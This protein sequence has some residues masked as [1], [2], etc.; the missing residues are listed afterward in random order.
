M[1]NKKYFADKGENNM[2]SRLFDELE[3]CCSLCEH[4][5]KIEVSG[6]YV[7]TRGSRLLRVE[8]DDVCRKFKIDLLSYRP[9]PAKLPRFDIND[10]SVL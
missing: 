9:M 4:A 6:E 1:E 7:C 2:K 5:M 3:P 10:G 8:P